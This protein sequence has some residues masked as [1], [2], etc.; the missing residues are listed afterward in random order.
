MS[1]NFK[2]IMDLELINEVPEGANVLIETDGATKRLPST[3]I[4]PAPIQS[5]FAQ[6]DPSAPDY[7]KNRTHYE[8]TSVVNE[9]LNITWD[10]NTEGLVSVNDAFYKVSDVVLTDEQ[11]KSGTLTV[12][13][14]NPLPLM[15]TWNS[16]VAEGKATEAFVNMNY[17]L[18]VVRQAGTTIDGILFPECGIYFAENVASLTTTEPVEHTKTVVK[19]LDKKFLPDDIGSGGALIVNLTWEK[20]WTFVP[21][22]TYQEAFDAIMSGKNVYLNYPDE[23]NPMFIRFQSIHPRDGSLEFVKVFGGNE[24]EISIE[25][26]YFGKNNKVGRD[27]ASGKLNELAPPV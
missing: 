4:K 16:L 13:G 26:Y 24:T 8:E 25:M 15:I 27:V 10:G 14:G 12:V 17:I 18:I 3:A 11:F 9:P 19:K 1:Y 2:K 22:V 7:V 6:N 5:D 20:D 21:S 23:Y